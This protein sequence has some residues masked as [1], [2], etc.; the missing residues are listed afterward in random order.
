MDPMFQGWIPA[1]QNP[2]LWDHIGSLLEQ[3]AYA[4]GFSLCVAV[5][6]IAL[7]ALLLGC[8]TAITLAIGHVESQCKRFVGYL[9]R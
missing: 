9:S 2:T 3:A 6:I 8:I 5:G 1:S 4:M 7:G